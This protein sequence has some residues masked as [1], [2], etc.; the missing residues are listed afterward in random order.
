M[1]Q[2]SS[3]IL[4]KFFIVT[5]SFNQVAYLERTINSVLSQTGSFEIHYFIVDGGSKDG[6][7]DILK[8]YSHKLS[9]T[10]EKDN[11]QT[12]AINKGIKYFK[13]FSEIDPKPT[14]FAYI[15]SDDYYLPSTF[16]KVQKAF[17]RN[18]NFDW[19]IGD[20]I[21][22][23]DKNQEIHKLLRLYKSFW[24]RFLSKGLLLVLNPIPQPSIFIRWNALKKIGYFNPTLKYTMDYEYW[25][26]LMKD[27][28]KPL[29]IST[30]LSAFRV[31]SKSKGGSQ[32]TQQ[33][34]E[35]L[36]VAKKFTNSKFYLF[37]HKIHKFLIIFIY[38]IIK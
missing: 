7:V 26:R 24:R 2:A 9:F 38:N 16:E 36:E 4:A 13:R 19:I 32:H 37:L 31:H 22:V 27:F 11:G 21:I 10:S 17:E 18:K 1:K 35:E 12:D 8:K 14:Y 23:N 34:E 6:S 3:K 28:Y 30:P 5:P 20:S 15:N 33:F 29:I 25:N